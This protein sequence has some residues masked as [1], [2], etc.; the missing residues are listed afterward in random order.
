[1][2]FAVIKTGGKQYK[3]ASGDSIM[4]EKLAT[5]SKTGDKVTFDEV[6]LKEIGG[7]TSVGA[8]FVKG[9]SVTATVV[10]V[11]RLDKVEVVRYRAKSRYHKRN[12]HRQP[13]IKVTV[14]AIK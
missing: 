5:E 12:G 9:S 10:E 14:D 4:I 13:Y 2:D 8:P 7:K 6:L 1:M 11:G 3:V